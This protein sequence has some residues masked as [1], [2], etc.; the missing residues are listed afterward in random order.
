MNCPKCG[1]TIRECTCAV[2]LALWRLAAAKR[3]EGRVEP[4]LP[5]LCEP[6]RTL[7]GCDTCR[8][9]GNRTVCDG[10]CNG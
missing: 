9:D 5:N 4:A 2:D 8:H 6:I 1:K 3:K 7:S 10:C